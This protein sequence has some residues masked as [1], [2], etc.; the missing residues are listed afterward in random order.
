[1][2]IGNMKVEFKLHVYLFTKNSLLFVFF[3]VRN[4]TGCR[5]NNMAPKYPCP[6]LRA[7]EWNVLR[8]RQG[9]TK[10][11][12]GTKVANQLEII[13]DYPGRPT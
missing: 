11:A 6:I 8:Y 10:V 4:E 2:H 9:E 7:H 13:L 12:D 5:Q 1:M 3:L